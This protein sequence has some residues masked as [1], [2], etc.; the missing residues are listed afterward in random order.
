MTKQRRNKNGKS[1]AEKKKEFD[2]LRRIAIYGPEIC[3]HSNVGVC[4][5]HCCFR[6]R[7]STFVICILD[8]FRQYSKQTTETEMNDYDAGETAKGNSI[9]ITYFYCQSCVY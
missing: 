4:M 3:T 6:M 5:C 7:M 8:H 2:G 1:D 9:F